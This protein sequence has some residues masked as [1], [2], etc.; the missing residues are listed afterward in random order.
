M[1][2]VDTEIGD[3]LP[4]RDHSPATY[5]KRETGILVVA[6]S[7]L[8]LAVCLQVRAEEKPA[9]SC[10]QRGQVR[11]ATLYTSMAAMMLQL[12]WHSR[13]SNERDG[14]S[15]CWLKLEIVDKVNQVETGEVFLVFAKYLRKR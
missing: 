6:S 1:L 8:S 9:G 11:Y 4:R 14:E 7:F 12:A 2:D 13:H 5:C 10:Y 15:E 3:L